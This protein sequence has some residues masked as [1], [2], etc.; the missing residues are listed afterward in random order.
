MKFKFG[1][2]KLLHHR[3]TIEDL[4]RREMLL[5]QQIVDLANMELRGM[6]EQIDLARLRASNIL[7]EQGPHA[8]AL[9]QIDE[10]IKLQH[11][12]IDQHRVKLREMMAELEQKQAVLVEAAKEKKTLEKLKE[13]RLH[14]FKRQ[15]K[16][17]ELKAIDEVVTT[18]FK[19]GAKNENGIR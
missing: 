4:A 3:Q 19:P 13:R 5:A 18:R 6:Y 12:R 16:K 15:N 17:R 7:R 2:E 9:A 11:V 10:F 14:E 1:Y 8:V